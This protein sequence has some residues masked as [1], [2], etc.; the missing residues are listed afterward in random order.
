MAF[1]DDVKNQLFDCLPDDFVDPAMGYPPC[2]ENQLT[3]LLYLLDLRGRIDWRRVRLLTPEN[4]V[5][6]TTADSIL[7]GPGS[8]VSEYPLFAW[9]DEEVRTWHQMA[10]DLV[11]LSD[12]NQRIVL[13][14]NKIG[15]NFTSGG[16]DVDTGQ[17]AR[18]VKYLLGCRIPEKHIVIISSGLFFDRGWYANELAATLG[19][20]DRRSELQGHLIC[21]EEIF[22]ATKSR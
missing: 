13:I 16:D 8:L 1:K 22:N 15:S 2:N 14:E 5:T 4:T 20:N 18:Q 7:S 3:G 10:A 17:L 9:D 12:D 19:R 11:F 6:N 21:W